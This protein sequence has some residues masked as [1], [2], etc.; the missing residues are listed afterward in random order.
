MNDEE[1]KSEAQLQNLQAIIEIEDEI[2]QAHLLKVID[3]G[4]YF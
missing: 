2:Q 3:I 4:K 1:K